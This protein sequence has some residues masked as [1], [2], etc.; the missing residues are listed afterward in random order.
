MRRARACHSA[1]SLAVE[2]PVSRGGMGA[3]PEMLPPTH[4][5]P[6]T[7]RSEVGDPGDAW[8]QPVSAYKH[9]YQPLAGI[10]YPWTAPSL[11]HVSVY[12]TWQVSAI[13]WMY[14]DTCSLVHLHDRGR[15]WTGPAHTPYTTYR[16]LTLHHT[17]LPRPRPYTT[18]WCKAAWHVSTSLRPAALRQLLVPCC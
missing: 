5:N 1:F 18:Q 7:P 10:L 3:G 11:Y 16:A 14:A 2:S 8:I 13:L 15:W 6:E 9:G 12:S 17:P 4:T